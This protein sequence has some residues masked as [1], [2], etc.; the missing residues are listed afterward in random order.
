MTKEKLLYEDDEVAAWLVVHG[1]GQKIVLVEL[2]SEPGNFVEVFAY[3]RGGLAVETKYPSFFVVVEQKMV[4]AVQLG[5]KPESEKREPDSGKS[6]A[7]G[8][9]DGVQG[10]A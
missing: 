10:P 8:S 5:E 6:P 7:Q 2:K 1:H 4:A 9:G 3:K